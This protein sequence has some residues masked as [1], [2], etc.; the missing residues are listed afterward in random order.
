M[1]FKHKTN[2]SFCQHNQAFQGI[3]LAGMEI[4]RMPSAN[5]KTT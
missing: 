1:T 3:S 5:L 4:E 2:L